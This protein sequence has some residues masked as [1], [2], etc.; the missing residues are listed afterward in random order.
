MYMMKKPIHHTLFSPQMSYWLILDVVMIYFQTGLN[1][2]K[3]G[4]KMHGFLLMGSTN[5]QI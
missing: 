4:L 1:L 5:C 2:I 3:L